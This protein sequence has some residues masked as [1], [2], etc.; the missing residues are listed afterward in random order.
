MAKI[1]SD[2]ELPLD[3]LT[4]GLAQVR[5]R[6][7]GAGIEELARSIAKQGL[8]QPIVVAPTDD[9]RYEIIL[10]QRRFLACKQLGFT[11]IRAQVLDEHIDE[12]EAKVLSLTENLMRRDINRRDKIDVCT[13]LYKRY[14]TIRD[15]AEETGLDYKEV[16][17]YVKYDR[18]DPQLKQLVDR[19]EVKLNVA[20]RAQDAAAASGTPR[21]EEA[22]ALAK[23]MSGMSGEQSRRL[24]KVREE[25]PDTPVDEVIEQA[26]EQVRVTQVLVTLGAEAHRALRAFTKEEGTT[27]DDAAG[28]LIAEALQARGYEL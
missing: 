21:A 13:V 27:Q 14:G 28:Q 9:G 3:D 6:D 7:V 1:I 25:T 12:M 8:L 23:E 22:I 17:Q 2:T 5:L 24:L 20:L 19:D 18:L 16:S 15:V 10:G 11:S 4:I 26:K